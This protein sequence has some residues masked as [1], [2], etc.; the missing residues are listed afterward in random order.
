MAKPEPLPLQVPDVTADNASP[1]FNVQSG[2]GQRDLCLEQSRDGG[3]LMTD[4][5]SELKLWTRDGRLLWTM[6]PHTDNFINDFAISPGT[7]SGSRLLE[8]MAL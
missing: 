4:T 3:F 5:G 2:L 7:P 8:T 1:E 6:K